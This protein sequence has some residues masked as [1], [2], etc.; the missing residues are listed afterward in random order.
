[1]GHKVVLFCLF[2]A[3]VQHAIGQSPIGRVLPCEEPDEDPDPQN[4]EDNLS[5]PNAGPFALD[6]YSRGQLCDGM[7]DCAGGSD[8]GINLPALDCSKFCVVRVVFLTP[9]SR[10]KTT[11]Q[12]L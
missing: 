11:V 9:I 4:P 8:E 1:M 12:S 7:S 6:C 5:C 3:V 10:N 2:L